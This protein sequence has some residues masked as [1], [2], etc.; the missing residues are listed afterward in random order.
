MKPR[1]IWSGLLKLS[2]LTIPVRLYTAVSE[3]EKVTFK[4]LHR[5]CHQRIRQQLVCP[6]HG[7][8]QR[9]ALVKGY[10]LER[11]RFVVLDPAELDAVRLESAHTIDLVQFTPAAD[12][13]VLHLEQPYYLGPDGPVA[14]EAFVVLREALRQSDRVGLGRL[15]MSGREKLV[16]LSPLGRGMV[17]TTL[18]YMCDVRLATD[19]FGY[20]SDHEPAA[21]Q[22]ALARK[23]IDS[24]TAPL[25]LAGFTD[26]YR[27]AVLDR[28]KAKLAGKS[29]VA[30]SQA[31]VTKVI[32]LMEALKRSVADTRKPTR[33]RG[34]KA[35][36][37]VA[38]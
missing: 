24:K 33:R 8:V 11:H 21:S 26:R 32:D 7:H 5:D 36:R 3:S 20:I 35:P 1:S 19:T 15:V 25:N 30:V 38:A 9:E 4:Q 23:L 27:E 6:V 34:R 31:P 29:P 2:L 13:D 28:V 14:E 12:L 17:L 22:L 10:E 16:S 18:R 37:A